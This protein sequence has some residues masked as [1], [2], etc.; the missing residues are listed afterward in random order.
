MKNEED[1]SKIKKLEEKIDRLQKSPINKI[2]VSNTI[3]LNEDKK[4]EKLEIIS[5]A[6]VFGEAI[7]RIVN[8][9]SLS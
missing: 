4:F 6:N 8:G 5:V 7:N 9:T 3:E 1:L 2:I